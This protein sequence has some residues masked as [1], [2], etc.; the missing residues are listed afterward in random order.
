M[1]SQRLGQ[2]YGT[3]E[4]LTVGGDKGD[5]G[6]RGAEEARG[7]ASKAVEPLFWSG[8]QEGGLPERSQPIGAIE[9][10]M[11]HVPGARLPPSAAAERVTWFSLPFG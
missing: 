8:I 5:E 7:H 10:T 3:L 6:S 1:R 11:G 9:Q 4:E 2:P